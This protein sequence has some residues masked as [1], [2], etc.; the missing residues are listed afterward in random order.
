MEDLAVTTGFAYHT[1]GLLLSKGISP[2]SPFAEL[3][4]SLTLS[5]LR[6]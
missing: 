2:F 3:Q 4:H 6:F 1:L 5:I